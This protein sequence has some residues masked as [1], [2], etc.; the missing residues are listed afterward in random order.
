VKQILVISVGILLIIGSY[1]V[2]TKYHDSLELEYY[3]GSAEE[4][5]M[6][7]SIISLDK[8]KKTNNFEQYLISSVFF[9]LMTINKYD[10]IKNRVNMQGYCE[11]IINIQDE[12]YDFNTSTKDLINQ[13]CKE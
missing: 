11:N 10:E 8:K 9:D 7:L 12:L 4:R 13:I 3:I 6:S 2:Y 5:S 1:F